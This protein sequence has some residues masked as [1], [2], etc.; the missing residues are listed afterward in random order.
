MLLSVVDT[1]MGTVC[2]AKN[3]QPKVL[4][5]YGCCIEC[6]WLWYPVSGLEGSES[7]GQP[8]AVHGSCDDGRSH[9]DVIGCHNMLLELL[10]VI[11]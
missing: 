4:A 3:G 9:L 6:Q 1:A 10:G 8:S 7:G 2:E 11:G 5:Y